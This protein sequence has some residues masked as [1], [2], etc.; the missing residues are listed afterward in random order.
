MF[1]MYTALWLKVALLC[2][3]G[4]KT[5][6]TIGRAVR[7]YYFHANTA[8]TLCQWHLYPKKIPPLGTPRT[9]SSKEVSFWKKSCEWRLGHSVTILGASF[10]GR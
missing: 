10:D 4:K 6:S 2:G 1:E 9:S 5:C 8:G 3:E 7:A